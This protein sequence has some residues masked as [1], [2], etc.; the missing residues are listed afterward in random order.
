MLAILM[1]FLVL[2]VCNAA[3]AADMSG[4]STA[5]HAQNQTANHL[6]GY[7]ST[8]TSSVHV[9]NAN[10]NSSQSNTVKTDFVQINTFESRQMNYNSTNFSSV[11]TNVA[12]QPSKVVISGKVKKCSTGE[13]FSGATVTAEKDGNVLA[14]TTANDDGTYNLELLSDDRSFTVTASYPGH[15][16]STKE[17]TVTPDSNGTLQ[18]S[19]DFELG[20]DDVYVSPAGNDSTGDGTQANPYQTIGKGVNEVNAGGRVHLADGT[21]QG[22]GS[23]GLTIN[24]DVTIIGESQNGT[25]IDAQGAD[26]MFN[27][28]PNTNVTLWN[29]TLK[30]GTANGDS[31]PDNAGGAVYNSG[32]LTVEKCTFSGNHAH[33]SGPDETGGDGGAI[34]NTGALQINDSIFTGNRAGD[35]GSGIIRIN[36]GGVF[37]VPGGNGGNGGA[38]YSTGT[39]NVTN[40]TFTGNRAGD[41]GNGESGGYGGSYGAIYN[42]GYLTVDN[43]TFSNNRAG[44]G[45]TGSYGGSG[46]YGGS[47]GSGGAIY[48]TNN[49]TVTGCTFSGN[50]AGNGGSSLGIVGRAGSG[51]SGGAIYCI[52]TLNITNSTFSNNW[53]GEGSYGPVYSSGGSG[54]AIYNSGT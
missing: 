48:S 47:G 29:L 23:R 51:G 50:H 10:F 6:A 38:I 17:V 13:P 18:G 54:G 45:G 28:A 37:F 19:A 32:N 35:G 33:D 16:S 24:K 49:L 46:V 27:I 2:A 43:C 25:V 26:R 21:Y 20:L 52:D 1:V 31:F 4:N 22:P 3:A 11:N 53:A 5:V 44:N 14:K 15:K 30:N 12:D 39:L 9:V 34:Y 7:N 41:G 36:G 40:S 8:N 42:S